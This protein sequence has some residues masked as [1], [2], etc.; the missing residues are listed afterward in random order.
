MSSARPPFL[1]LAVFVALASLPACRSPRIAGPQ[2]FVP[3]TV[4]SASPQAPRAPQASPVA[5]QGPAPKAPVLGTRRGRVGDVRLSARDLAPVDW[6]VD[7]QNAQ[8]I[9]GDEVMVEASR[10]Y[11]GQSL[12]VNARVGAVERSDEVHPDVTIIT[13]RFLMAP[14]QNAVENNPRVLIGTGL[15]VSARRVLRVRLFKTQDANTPV[16][17]RVTATGDASRGRKERVEG[18]APT[19]QVG[20][21]LRRAT[22]GWAWF[23]IG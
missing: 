17:L 8:W 5:Q 3:T 6:Y 11:F 10:E 2:G 9:L 22:S 13:L 19:L 7:A 16:S 18:R 4:P 12:T 21:S 15:T 23:P 14:S 1:A 20:G